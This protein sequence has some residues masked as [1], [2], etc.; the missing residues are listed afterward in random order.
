MKNIVVD[1]FY[2]SFSGNISVCFVLCALL[3]FRAQ[4]AEITDMWVALLSY[5]FKNFA[6][7]LSFVLATFG[8]LMF[9]MGQSSSIFFAEYAMN[10]IIPVIVLMFMEF[11][12]FLLMIFNYFLHSQTKSSILSGTGAWDKSAPAKE[13][14]LLFKKPSLALLQ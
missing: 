10:H 8:G 7:F 12:A 6:N 1:G 5:I 9:S 2:S 11:A 13:P 14:I 3:L 4:I